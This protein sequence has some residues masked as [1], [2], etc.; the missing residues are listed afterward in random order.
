MSDGISS[1]VS[2]LTRTLRS[3]EAIAWDAAHFV[4]WRGDPALVLK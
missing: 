2:L 1:L 4:A 3:V